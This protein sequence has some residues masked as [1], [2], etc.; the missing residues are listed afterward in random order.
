MRK[1][2]V[3]VILVVLV[4]GTIVNAFQDDW[5]KFTSPENRYSVLMPHKPTAEVIPNSNGKGSH[6]RFSD[7]EAGYA[8]VIEDLH[9][10]G[11]TN[12]EAYLDGVR[13]GVLKELNASLLSETKITTSGFPGRELK[14]AAE[15]STKVPFI[16]RTRMYV[17]GGSFYSLSFVYA[18]SLDADYVDKIA[19]RYFGSIKFNPVP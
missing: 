4:F 1:N 13:D 11:A 3:I 19:E 16:S 18:K 2:N 9:D 14:L 5:Y 8:F 7:V 12:A 6:N 10:S 17:V 15:T